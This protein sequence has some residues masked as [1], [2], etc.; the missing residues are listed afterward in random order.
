MVE[1]VHQ[2][3]AQLVVVEVVDPPVVLSTQHLV[4][5]V[6]KRVSDTMVMVVVLVDREV[7]QHIGQHIGK[8][9]YLNQ[10]VVH[11]QQKMD[12]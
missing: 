1:M 10:Q 12:M 3:D 11:Y 2:V 8:V 5:L 9:V 6:D 7:Y 4:V